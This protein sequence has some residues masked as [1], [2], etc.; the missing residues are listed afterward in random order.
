MIFV[1]EGMHSI[2]GRLRGVKH[3]MGLG[4]EIERME[5]G[6][7]VVPSGLDQLVQRPGG[8]KRK[9]DEGGDQGDAAQVTRGKKRARE[10]QGDAGPSGLSIQEKARLAGLKKRAIGGKGKNTAGARLPSVIWEN[11]H[12]VYDLTDW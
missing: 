11:G 10:G 3:C 8:G 12:P 2:L 6:I 1:S 9:E 5:S 7:Q 4:A